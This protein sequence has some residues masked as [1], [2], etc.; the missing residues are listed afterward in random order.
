LFIL[1]L[2]KGKS[3]F[4]Y[5]LIAY[6]VVKKIPF[7]YDTVASEAKLYYFNGN[8]FECLKKQ[9]DELSKLD[10]N[11]LYIVDGKKPLAT[12]RR[13]VLICSADPR[14]YQSFSDKSINC[15]YYMPYWSLNELHDCINC[16]EVTDLAIVAKWKEAC[17]ELHLQYG[18]V[19]RFV[20]QHS[21]EK[22]K[23]GAESNNFY[24]TLQAKLAKFTYENVIKYFDSKEVH[25]RILSHLVIHFRVNKD[26][27]EFGLK[28]ASDYIK[29]HMDENKN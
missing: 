19:P 6:L 29:A 11:T 23:D 17:S 26:F 8:S 27:R 13:V 20:L 4:G 5:Y 28:F 10:E 9:D 24:E 15:Q 2:F 18:G 12:V 3:Y 21:R 1:L 14:H 22:V 16:I 25:N 7:V